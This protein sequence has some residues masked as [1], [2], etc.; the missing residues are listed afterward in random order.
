M[1]EELGGPTPP[2]HVPQLPSPGGQ[3]PGSGGAVG[4]PG[5]A[6]GAGG[7]RL[8]PPRPGPTLGG[9]GLSASG[10]LPPGSLAS[11]PLREA[12]GPVGAST[13]LG[14]PSPLGPPAGGLGG[15]EAATQRPHASRPG[16]G[17]NVLGLGPDARAVGRDEPLSVVV[18]GPPPPARVAAGPASRGASGWSPAPTL[19]VLTEDV[20]AE[21]ESMAS[22]AAEAK[23]D[24]EV[25]ELQAGAQAAGGT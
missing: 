21:E 22:G 10:P 5:P 23:A 20:T 15:Q 8:D 1:R 12:G 16:S 24:A 19:P 14:P 7:L 4:P 25:A 2:L 11:A 9:P 6:P 13:A 17:G 18:L 3:R